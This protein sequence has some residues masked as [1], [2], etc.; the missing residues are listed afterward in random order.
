MGKRYHADPRNTL[1]DDFV[2]I[3]LGLRPNAFLME[4][5]PSMQMGATAVILK[6]AIKRLSTCYQI[7][8]PV[9]TLNAANFGVPQRRERLFVMGILKELDVEIP[10][11]CPQ[12]PARPTIWASDR[13]PAL[14]S[15]P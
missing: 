10:Y 3:V 5:V 7:T 9:R 8:A 13:R 11:P 4:N 12:Q 6:R 14:V 2:R 15:W 1:V